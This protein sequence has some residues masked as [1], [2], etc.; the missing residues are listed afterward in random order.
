MSNPLADGIAEAFTRRS[1]EPEGPDSTSEL[2]ERISRALGLAYR[3]RYGGNSNDYVGPD[4]LLD[5]L[6]ALIGAAVA[7][8][9]R[10]LL[11]EIVESNE[12][13]CRFDHH[14]NCQAHGVV[15]PPCWFPPLLAE[16]NAR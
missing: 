4:W 15:E 3:A 12:P 2:R 10:P 9:R 8:G 11:Q 13:E 7:A 14:G 5:A 6:E 1:S 16:W